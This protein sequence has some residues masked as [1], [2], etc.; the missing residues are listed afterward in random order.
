[1]QGALTGVP[2]S[3]RGR[4]AGFAAG[5]APTSTAGQV[6]VRWHRNLPTMRAALARLP[7]RDG[8]EPDAWTA[9]LP[10]R[11]VGDVRVVVLA[12]AAALADEGR[13]GTCADGSD[14]LDRCV[15]EYGAACRAGA[16]RIVFLRDAVSGERLSTVELALADGGV[17]VAQRRGC[18]NADPSAR[19]M[20]A[21]DRYLTWFG[22]DT[23][24]VNRAAF[25]A[26][27]CTSGTPGPLDP[28]RAG[29][30]AAVPGNW[31]TARDAWSWHLPRAVMCLG[32]TDFAGSRR[33][34]VIRRWAGATRH[35]HGS[36]RE[37]TKV[38]SRCPRNRPA[39][40]GQADDAWR[41]PRMR[42]GSVT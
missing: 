24:R 31:E 39:L 32:T 30:A 23:G 11:R 15:G 25:R 20:H 35:A 1:M 3:F 27:P 17:A 10:G 28:A 29:Y 26:S 19:A 36:P 16:V 40:A 33:R 13:R 4:E 2:P 7:G 21:L 37:R 22:G 18:G 42:P 38:A 8:R 34:P 9:G 12:T 5:V 14:G 41:Q 6:A